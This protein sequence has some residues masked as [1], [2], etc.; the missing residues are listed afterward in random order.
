MVDFFLLRL[1]PVILLCFNAIYFIV[2]FCI[3]PSQGSAQQAAVSPEVFTLEHCRVFMI[4]LLSCV[5]TLYFMTAVGAHRDS[6]ASSPGTWSSLPAV[7]A[8]EFSGILT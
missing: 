2:A 6:A 4:I 1:H 8:A 5:Y 3:L 7:S